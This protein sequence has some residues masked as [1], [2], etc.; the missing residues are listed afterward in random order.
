MVFLLFDDGLALAES[1]KSKSGIL[2]WQ[3]S[4][5]EMSEYRSLI[6][7]LSTVKQSD[8]SNN[9]FGVTDLGSTT[10]SFKPADDRTSSLSV[11]GTIGDSFWLMSRDEISTLALVPPSVLDIYY[12][13]HAVPE[14][15]TTWLPKNLQIDISPIG[16]NPAKQDSS[17]I[18]VWKPTIE[19]ANALLQHTKLQSS[20]LC[21]ADLLSLCN[22]QGR[23]I[24]TTL[25]NKVFNVELSGSQQWGQN[26]VLKERS[27]LIE[28][29]GN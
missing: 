28:N 17:D 19:T 5:E 1:D 11:E 26:S 8:I 6:K 22:L 12:K 27:N 29:R 7:K 24:H 14:S 25:G 16:P 20:E 23:I 4:A 13:T 9:V 21:D 10:Y 15:G 3:A 2:T 18:A